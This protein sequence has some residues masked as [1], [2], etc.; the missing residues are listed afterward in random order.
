MERII[1][2]VVTLL[3]SVAVR[4]I[5]KPLLVLMAKVLILS[6]DWTYIYLLNRFSNDLI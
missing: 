5:S 3:S 6:L 1:W 2:D 4:T